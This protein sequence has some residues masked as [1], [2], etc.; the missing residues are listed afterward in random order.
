MSKYCGCAN[1]GTYG[2]G[3]DDVSVEINSMGA[4]V[5]QLL[6]RPEVYNGQIKWFCWENSFAE[7]SVGLSFFVGTTR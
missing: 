4:I 7:R 3:Y 5:S 6:C 2:L 1:Y